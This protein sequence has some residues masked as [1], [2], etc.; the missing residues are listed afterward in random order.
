MAAWFSAGKRGGGAPAWPKLPSGDDV[1]PVFL[2]HVDG[3][4][5]DIELTLNLLRAYS[6][7]SVTQYPRDGV[8]GEIIAGFPGAG[9]DVYIPETLLAE[10]REIMSAEVAD[11]EV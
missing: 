4:T 10:A 7:P 11:D 2:T 8:I 6:I 9:A 1:A 5:F 3:G